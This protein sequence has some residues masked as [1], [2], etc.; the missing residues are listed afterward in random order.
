MTPLP[1]HFFRL[2]FLKDPAAAPG[3][4][5]H[6]RGRCSPPPRFGTL[7]AGCLTLSSKTSSCHKDTRHL[8]FFKTKSINYDW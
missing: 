2:A 7:H 5:C 1:L 4:S 6:Y 3:R 8:I